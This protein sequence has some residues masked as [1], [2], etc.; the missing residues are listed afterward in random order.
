MPQ[1]IPNPLVNGHRVSRSSCNMVMAGVVISAWKAFDFSSELTPGEVKGSGSLLIGRT[2]GA[3]KFTSSI[4][5]YY[6]EFVGLVLPAIAAINPARGYGENEFDVNFHCFEE[7]GAIGPLGN[8]YIQGARI[9]KDADSVGD[10]DDALTV[11][12][13]LHPMRIY[14]NNQIIVRD[15]VLA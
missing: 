7:F 12:L 1:P 13:D 14:R 10:N 5:I 15:V 6:E 2:R 4:E 9:T 8:V 3:A 11:K